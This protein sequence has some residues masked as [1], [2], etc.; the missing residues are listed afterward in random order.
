MSECKRCRDRGKTWSGDDPRCAFP[1]GVFT[2]H[3]WNCATMNILRD[4]ADKFGKTYRDDNSCGSFGYIPMDHDYAPDDFDTLGGYIA[5]AWYKER[6]KTGNAV[7]MTDDETV[8][9]TTK[10]AELA[11]HTSEVWSKR[12]R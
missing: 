4:I 8:P 7:F 9:L 11:I 2:S 5:M 1:D 10:H 6:G 3:N 12:R